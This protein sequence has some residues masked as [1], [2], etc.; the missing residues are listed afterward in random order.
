MNRY[1]VDAEIRIMDDALRQFKDLVDNGYD[2][3]FRIYE[4]Y[5]T[6]QVPVQ[7]NAFMGNGHADDYFKCEQY[8]TVNCCS[9]CRYAT[10][11]ENCD[12]SSGC[13]NGPGYH[14]I[15]CPTDY[16]DGSDGIDWYNT[17]VPN[18][19]Y[20]LVDSDA[21]YK[22]ISD[23][24]GLAESW[25]AFG[26]VGVRTANGCQY[27]G[28]DIKDCQKQQD[29]WFWNYPTAGSVKVF[30]PKDV[31]GESYDKSQDL[32]RRL[33]IMRAISSYDDYLQ[34]SDLVDAAALPSLSM[35]MA[36]ES[37]QAVVKAA[38]DIKKAQ[39]EEMILSFVTGVLFF[40]P[41][42]GD[43][44]GATGMTAVR[45]SLELLGAAGDAGLL[46]YGIVED[47]KNAFMTIFSTLA[48]AGL[49]RAGW[50]D[51]ANARRDMSADD[52]GKLGSIKNKID[53]I[54][55]VRIR[56]CKI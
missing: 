29:T 35:Q 40:I 13:Q 5:T 36:M 1:I 25:I 20:T 24:Y 46:A 23:E 55:D 4:E 31:I 6:E 42:A 47:P 44:A 48:G 51:A 28:K 16:K 50:R 26:D 2:D 53:L 14:K 49:G 41:F 22:A 21:F 32:L 7:I 27:A 19:T 18:V 30:N 11:N 56:S 15:T 8:S 10:C 45:T 52:I 9:S 54:Q 38:D 34:W 37:M 39:R 12:N 33:K 3:K 17:K 43:A